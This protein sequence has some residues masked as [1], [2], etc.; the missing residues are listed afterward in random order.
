MNKTQKV[1]LWTAVGSILTLITTHYLGKPIIR[2]IDD[3]FVKLSPRNFNSSINADNAYL[4]ILPENQQIFIEKYKN[5]HVITTADTQLYYNPFTEQKA[6]ISKE[7]DADVPA[8]FLT[9]NFKN[10]KGIIYAQIVNNSTS[11]WINKQT[12]KPL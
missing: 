11:A 6:S 8:G 12:I 5:K 2:A 3:F 1:I 9:G 10:H 4:S 7:L